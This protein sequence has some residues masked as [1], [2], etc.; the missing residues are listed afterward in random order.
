MSRL[1]YRRLLIAVVLMAAIVAVFWP[2]LGHDFVNYDDDEYI[3]GNPWVQQGFTAESVRWAWTTTHFYWHP[4]TWMSH[5]LDWELFGPWAGGHHAVSLALHAAN[6]LLVFLLLE[7]LTGATWRSALVAVLFGVHPLRVESVAWAAERK[8]VLSACFWLLTTWAYVAW[9]RRRGLARYL[10]VVGGL[11]LGL[12]TKPMLVTLP[13]TLVLLDWWPL[14][15]LQSAADFWP[16]IR[17]KLPLVPL[18][19]ASVAVS[20]AF[21]GAA[22]IGSLETYPLG[23]RAANALVSYVAYLGM[24]VWPREL[25]VLYLHPGANIPAW[26]VAGAAA[27]LLAITVVAVLARSRAPA[28]LFGCLWYLGTLVPVI[29]IVQAGE[30]A[31]ADRFTYVPLVGV[32]VAVAWLLPA[33][34]RLVPAVA[35]AS[36][37][38][39]AVRAHGQVGIWRDAVTLFGHAVAVDPKNP[40]AHL[41]LGVALSERGE[42]ERAKVHYEEALRLRPHYAE[43]VNALGNAALD[44]GDTAEAIA[45]YSA[46]LRIAPTYAIALNNLGYALA[47]A[48]RIREAIPAYEEALR[49]DPALGKAENNLGI[50]R[51]RTGDLAAA[52][53]HFEAAIRLDPRH[54]DALSNLGALM[55]AGGDAAAGLAYIDRALAVRPDLGGAH[56]NR[57]LALV[58]LGRWQEAWEAVRRA[59][60]HGAEPPAA[61]LARLRAHAPEPAP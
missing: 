53:A 50:A 24:T 22:T 60:A 40:I 42:L 20:I 35:V 26:E 30:Q 29:G 37:V 1:P 41:N 21:A 56:A 34:P 46:A 25:A 2:I 17:E 16:R 12:M 32:F 44:R 13:A 5:M 31:M 55:V 51:A 43:V 8:D 36:V 9:V 49:I 54:A 4:L 3:T 39:F 59:R 61:L 52:R 19:I 45:H 48:G 14:G 15:R 23:V 38:A 11:A 6:T 47:R 18:V 28:L 10:L 7:R 27:V 58:E 57:A 33:W